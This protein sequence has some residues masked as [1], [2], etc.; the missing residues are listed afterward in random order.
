M[1]I[2]AYRSLYG[3]LSKLK[4]ASLLDDPASGGGAD[5]ELFQL[6]L[7]VSEAVDNY[8]NRR[9]YA[10]TEGRYFDGN[11]DALL[12]VPDLITA[13]SIA[14][15]ENDDGEYETAWSAADYQLLP[16]N[17]SPTAHWGSPYNAV[18]ARSSGARRQFARGEARVRISGMWGYGER[19]EPSGSLLAGS[20]GSAAGSLTVDRVSDFAAGQTIAV[21][22]ER[23]LVTGTGTQ[24]LTV[25]RGLNGT[26][27]AAHA[28]NA[29]VSIVRWPAPVERAALINAARIWTRAPAF[30]PFYVGPG[31]DTDVRMLLE[32]YRLGAA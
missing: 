4:D 19:L 17:A 23:M 21:G 24:G 28:D 15:D 26:A 3:D 22:D 18:R 25:R 7:A 30:E 12:P 2:E 13:S 14:T 6:L 11:G 16:L 27:P 29:A 20:A 5:T 8:C 1:A 32:P 9:F 10:V 31:M